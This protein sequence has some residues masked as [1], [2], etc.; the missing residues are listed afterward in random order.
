MLFKSADLAVAL[1]L[2]VEHRKLSMK[3]RRTEWHWVGMPWEWGGEGKWLFHHRALPASYPSPRGGPDRISMK[4]NLKATVLD[5]VCMSHL[6]LKLNQIKSEHLK[7]TEFEG[8]LY[9]NCAVLNSS[10]M[11]F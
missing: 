9:L 6:P 7:V 1:F 2:L 8:V 10:L 3:E 5:G 11:F 4:Y